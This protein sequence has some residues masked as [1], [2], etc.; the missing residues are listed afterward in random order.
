MERFLLHAIDFLKRNRRGSAGD[1]PLSV[2]TKLGFSPTNSFMRSTFAA[3]IPDWFSCHTSGDSE[4]KIW[5]RFQREY[6]ESVDDESDDDESDDE[7]SDDEH[8]LRIISTVF[9]PDSKTVAS[10]SIDGKVRFWCVETGRCKQTLEVYSEPEKMFD[11]SICF[12]HDSKTMAI[13][14]Q[15]QAAPVQ[16]WSVETGECHQVPC[17]GLGEGRKFVAF[18]H[19]SKTVFMASDPGIV[20]TWN[21]GTD[22]FR[23]VQLEGMS[24]EMEAITFPPDLKSVST[25]SEDGVVQVWSIETGKC[26]QSVSLEPHHEGESFWGHMAISHDSRSVAFYTRHPHLEIGFWSI[27]TGKCRQAIEVD[28]RAP[29]HF[30]VGDATLVTS[31]GVFPLMDGSSSSP[32]PKPPHSYLS[33]A[34]GLCVNEIRGIVSWQGSELLLLPNECSL[35]EAA[36]SGSYVGFGCDT[37]RMVFLRF[38]TVLMEEMSRPEE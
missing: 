21:L 36:V 20:R 16:I 13:I 24:Q 15:D 7:E 38:D 37:G 22:E 29:P 32:P 17:E 33:P 26:Q 34:S 8:D 5:H 18:S 12:S 1:K 23:D 2:Y 4:W 6:S 31:F 27:K 14:L 11:I 30:G 35:S 19:D 10:A 9:S 28:T 25:G 3:D